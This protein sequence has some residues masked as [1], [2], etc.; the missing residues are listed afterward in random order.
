MGPWQD[1]K[2]T[3]LKLEALK[4]WVSSVAD[5]SERINVWAGY[6]FPG[7][8][9]KCSSADNILRVFFLNTSVFCGLFGSACLARQGFGSGAGL[10]EPVC[11]H[12]DNEP[13]RNPEFLYLIAPYLWACALCVFALDG[14]TGGAGSVNTVAVFNGLVVSC[15]GL[16]WLLK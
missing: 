8:E 13:R 10:C 4:H 14:S 2:R 11:A 6:P 12:G 9:S 7:Q 16:Y 3:T 1:Q 5:P 15:V